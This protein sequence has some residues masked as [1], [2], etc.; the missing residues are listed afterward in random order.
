MSK[1]KI[2]MGNVTLPDGIAI[3]IGDVA[4][5]A[6]QMFQTVKTQQPYLQK[7]LGTSIFLSI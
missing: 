1:K 3:R 6:C 2:E 7:P 4:I 5:L